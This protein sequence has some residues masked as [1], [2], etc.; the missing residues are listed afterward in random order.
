MDVFSLSNWRS[1]HC[2]KQFLAVQFSKGRVFRYWSL[3]QSGVKID[4]K[5]RRDEATE[6]RT[7]L[8]LN[9]LL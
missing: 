7:L 9:V 6:A 3:S 5:G 2:S 4:I 8:E 1:R